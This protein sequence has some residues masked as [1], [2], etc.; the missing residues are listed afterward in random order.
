MPE[1]LKIL[2]IEDDPDDVEFLRDALDEHA[3]DYQLDLVMRGDLVLS[4]MQSARVIPD[5]IVMDLNL[6]KIHGREVICQIKE[7]S[8]FGNVPVMVLTTSSL[9]EDKEHCLSKGAD[10]FLTKPSSPEGYQQLISF[11]VN[12]RPK[13]ESQAH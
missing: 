13:R 11:L 5:L 4:W 9:H 6:P 10:A 2:L 3:P 1:A 7:N 12:L 8:R